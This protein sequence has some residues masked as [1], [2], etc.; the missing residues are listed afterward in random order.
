MG[1]AARGAVAEGLLNACLGLAARY[2]HTRSDSRPRLP[3]SSIRCHIVRRGPGSLLTKG[4][5]MTVV[6]LHSLV[7]RLV[8]ISTHPNRF[9]SNP[10]KCSRSHPKSEH[11]KTGVSPPLLPPPKGQPRAVCR[12]LV[13]HGSEKINTYTHALRCQHMARVRKLHSMCRHA[14]LP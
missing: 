2:T 6:V 12:T 13:S 11:C 10:S 1:H 3:E 5:L 9:I 8:C 14:F 4:G 7:P